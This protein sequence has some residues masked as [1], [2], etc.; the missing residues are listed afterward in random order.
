MTNAGRQAR[1]R[2]MRLTGAATVAAAL[3]A[4]LALP[5]CAPAGNTPTPIAATP[6]T[7]DRAA[8][9]DDISIEIRLRPDG[10]EEEVIKFDDP[11]HVAVLEFTIQPGAVFPWHTHPGLAFAGIDQGELIYVYA[12]DCVERT[13]PAGAMFVDPGGDNVHTAYNPSESRETVVVATFIN[14]PAEGALTLPVDEEESARL[15]EK[16]RIDR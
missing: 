14:T 11:S 13:Y 8:L 15:D 9:T 16:C 1:Y 3:G 7:S 10:R 5:S 6:L 2:G 4:A 12:D